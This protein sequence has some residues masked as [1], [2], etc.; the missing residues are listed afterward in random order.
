MARDAGS[1]RIFHRFFFPP[2]DIEED[3]SA[4]NKNLISQKNKKLIR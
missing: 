1:F 3:V 2:T 4:F